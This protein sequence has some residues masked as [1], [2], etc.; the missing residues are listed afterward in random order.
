MISTNSSGKF[1]PT[2]KNLFR[3]NIAY[4]VVSQLIA[5][6]FSVSAVKTYFFNGDY[7]LQDLTELVMAISLLG[8]LHGVIMPLVLFR[9]IYS[10]RASDFFFSLPVKRSVYYNA[11]VFFGLINT[12]V[13]YAIAVGVTIGGVLIKSAALDYSGFLRIIAIAFLVSEAIFVISASCAVLSGRMWHYFLLEYVFIFE[14]CF[15]AVGLACYISTIRG[16]SID[17]NNSWMTTPVG[18]I[19][20]M[21]FDEVEDKAWLVIAVL[22]AQILIA[23]L[24]GL[25]IFKRRKAEVA[26]SSFSE[27]AAP[28]VT[29]TVWIFSIVFLILSLADINFYLRIIMIAAS[30]FVTAV[31]CSAAFYRKVLSKGIIK[32]V[33]IAA[34]ISVITVLCVEKPPQKFV[35]YVPEPSEV[36]YVTVYGKDSSGAMANIADIFYGN[37][38]GSDNDFEE[39]NAYRFSEEESKEL[40]AKLHK[41]LVEQ[42][43]AEDENRHYSIKL[44]YVLKNGKKV[45]RIYDFPADSVKYEYAALLMSDEGISQNSDF[46]IEEDILFAEIN[47]NIPEAFTYKSKPADE[48]SYFKSDDYSELVE[49]VK[50]DRRNGSVDHFL[51]LNAD[52]G[53]W[54]PIPDDSEAEIGCINLYYLSENAPEEEKTKILN[55]SPEDAVEY[56]REYF[57][58]PF[59]ASPLLETK[60][61]VIEKTDCETFFYLEKLGY[62]FDEAEFDRLWKERVS[63]ADT[64]AVE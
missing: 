48:F 24:A 18:T 39:I 4:F 25:I 34:V 16:I 50:K 7:Y 56:A 3:R 6:L 8:L 1:F 31:I 49:S 20:L 2:V 57:N 23:Y 42:K 46:K 38:I 62:S 44:S 21:L 41:K 15:G 45:N 53:W 17:I 59:S 60:S 33:A 11:N 13:S 47:L 27:K 35:M 29:V 36:E 12:A 22:L 10:R 43:N 19:M 37:S 52:Y 61:Y 64:N 40:A 14:L 63:E 30:V 26:E 32:C 5:A 55:M 51:I 54:F 9:E 58:K 28:A